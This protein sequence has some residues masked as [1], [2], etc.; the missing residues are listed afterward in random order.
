MQQLM[1]FVAGPLFRLTFAIMLL[2]LLRIVVLTVWGVIQARRQTD[3]KVMPWKLISENTVGWLVP[4]LRLWKTRPIYSVV[5]FVFHIGLILVPIFLFGHVQLIRESIGIGWPVMSDNLADILTIITMITAL[6][7]FLGRLFSKEARFISRPQDYVWP[8]LLAIP[9]VTGYVCNNMAIGAGV[10]QWTMLFHM[11]SAEL[12]F[13][14]IPFT[15]IAHCVLVPFSQMVSSLGW[16]FPPKSGEGVAET[17][18]K[19]EMPV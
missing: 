16:K 13:V 12:I 7:L 6:A 5:S 18:G 19:K 4:V 1:E 8:I 2:G 9:F 3:D 15:K 14:F 10:Y 17:L 11:L